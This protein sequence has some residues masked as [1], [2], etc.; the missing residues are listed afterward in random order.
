MNRGK[1]STER[2]NSSWLRGDI[3]ATCDVLVKGGPDLEGLGSHGPIIHGDT[4]A[5]LVFVR[6][7]VKHMIIYLRHVHGLIPVWGILLGVNN[8]ENLS[9]EYNSSLLSPHQCLLFL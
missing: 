6:T 2:Q 1:P 8:D 5:I 9:A 3:L 4:K 7:F